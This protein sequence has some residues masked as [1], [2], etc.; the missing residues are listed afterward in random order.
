MTDKCT[1]AAPLMAVES[2]AFFERCFAEFKQCDARRARLLRRMADIRAEV[3]GGSA[4][5][6]GGDSFSGAGDDGELPRA[7]IPGLV[8]D[9][10]DRTE[11]EDEA[12]RERGYFDLQAQANQALE[13]AGHTANRIFASA[14]ASPA[15]IRV[16]LAVLRRAL[17][18]RG[19]QDDG[20]ED[21]EAYQEVAPV[22]WLDSLEQDIARLDKESALPPAG[23]HHADMATSSKS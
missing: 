6:S 10:L 14:A 23:S 11:R 5:P 1:D 21:L 9:F 19:A 15:A 17:G 8:A 22:M 3:G 4:S 16:K 12:L 13:C 20:D 7:D 18:R 2:D